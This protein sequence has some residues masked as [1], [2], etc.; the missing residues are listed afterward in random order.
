MHIQ[1]VV[2][3]GSSQGKFSAVLFCQSYA[4]Y[5][6]ALTLQV[7]QLFNLDSVGNTIINLGMVNTIPCM[8]TAD[9]TL[10]QRAD[11]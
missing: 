2:L 4:I 7:I 1:P 10:G 9:F 6:H 3:V 5:Q 8:C 11:G